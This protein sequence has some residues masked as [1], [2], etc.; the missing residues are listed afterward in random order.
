MLGDEQVSAYVVLLS[1]FVEPEFRRQGYGSA[2]IAELV[3]LAKEEG[4]SCIYVRVTRK[5]NAFQKFLEKNE[6]GASPTKILY[7]RRVRTML[8]VAR[9]FSRFLNKYKTEKAKP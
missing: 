2:L 6:F 8:S 4:I 9:R 7:Q 3:N 5:N 1:I